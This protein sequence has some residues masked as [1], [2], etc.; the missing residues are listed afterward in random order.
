VTAKKLEAFASASS[1]AFPAAAERVNQ[2]GV[3]RHRF[4][5]NDNEIIVV[6][7]WPDEESFHAFFQTS[8]EIAGYEMGGNHAPT[9]RA[10]AS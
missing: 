9:A 7:E 4:Y 8:P 2:Y 3:I 1:A 10:G 5:D 6:D